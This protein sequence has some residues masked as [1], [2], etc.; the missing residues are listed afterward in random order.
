MAGRMTGSVTRKKV[1]HRR[2][3]EVHRRLLERAVE[4]HQPRLHDD[5][6]EAHG[7]GDVR[8]RHRA[9]A[10]VETHRDEQQQQRQAGDDFRHDQRR[11]HHAGKQHA[12]AE[13]RVARQRER[14]QRAENGRDGRRNDARRGPSPRRHPSARDWQNSDTYHLVENPP[15][16]VTSFE[17]LKEKM[18]RM[19][20]GR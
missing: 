3:A 9:E 11:E 13:A 14:R 18:T 4:G 5:G 20:I 15:H 12:A 2:R 17:A 6:D 10:A 7:E 19:T 16:T 8:E 1:A